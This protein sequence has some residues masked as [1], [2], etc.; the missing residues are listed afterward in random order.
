MGGTLGNGN[1][2]EDPMFLNVSEY[3]FRI[4]EN[5]PCIDSGDPLNPPDPDSTNTDI[6]RYYY[7]QAKV[8]TEGDDVECFPPIPVPVLQNYPNPFNPVTTIIF[9]VEE[10]DIVGREGVVDLSIYDIRG[11]KITTLYRQLQRAGKYSVTWN[12]QDR[13]GTDVPSGIYFYR[14]T[15]GAV[16]MMK[17]MVLMR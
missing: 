8:V 4:S 3:D 12:G 2:F 1:I 9:K 15:S 6:G 11:K 16:S 10:D 17:K 13:Y 7:D 14:L 5:S